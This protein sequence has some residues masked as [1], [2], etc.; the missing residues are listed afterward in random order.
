MIQF[1][2]D[3]PDEPAK[4]SGLEWL[5]YIW[6]KTM[7][8]SF[9]YQY[10]ILCCNCRT[11]LLGLLKG[12]FMDFMYH[13]LIWAHQTR[14]V[15]SSR[16]VFCFF[17]NDQLRSFFC[18]HLQMFVICCNKNTIFRTTMR[19]SKYFVHYLFF[20]RFIISII[21]PYFHFQKLFIDVTD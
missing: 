14:E 3:V 20:I 7:S 1:A 16:M 11:F 6:T 13:Q 12:N 4:D 8:W 17:L 18:R 10:F 2:R 21:L 9:S 19:E 15:V 5:W